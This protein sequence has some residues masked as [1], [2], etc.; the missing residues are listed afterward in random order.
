MAMDQA[1][2][3]RG[4]SSPEFLKHYRSEEQCRAA[5]FQWRRPADFACPEC[6]HTD[7]CEVARRG[8][9]ECHR[10]HH[11]TLLI[12]GTILED[13]TPALALKQQLGSA[14]SSDR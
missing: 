13:T 3:Q 11:Q 4:L 7:C 10:C 5:M 1:H 2:Y 8:L 14:T 12:S 6:A 9:Y